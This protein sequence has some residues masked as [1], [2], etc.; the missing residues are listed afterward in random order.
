MYLETLKKQLKYDMTDKYY[1]MPKDF[2]KAD[3]R[4]SE[5][6]QKKRDEEKAR[7]DHEAAMKMQKQNDKIKAISDGLRKMPDL[8]KFLDGS[9]GFLVYVP[10][11]AEDLMTEGRIQ[12]NCIG[13]YVD[14]VAS[15]KT[16]LFFIRKLDCP[17]APF[18]AMEYCNGDIIQCRYDHNIDVFTGKDSCGNQVMDIDN[19]LIDFTNSLAE[20]L[21]KNKVMVA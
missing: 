18:V 16:L 2:R 3:L 13:T 15:N 7:R 19:N 12:H 9:R 21:R 6:L 17:D 20:I 11:N 1:I 8:Q 5:E 14:R 4:A 10:E